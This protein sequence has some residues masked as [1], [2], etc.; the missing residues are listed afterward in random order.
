MKELD[1]EIVTGAGTGEVECEFLTGIAGSGKTF[2][3]RRRI[4]EDPDYGV[5]CA[6]TGIAAVNLGE[7]VTTLNSLLRYYNTDSLEMAH[8]T[9]RLARRL[10]DLAL[11]EGVRNI[12]I[13]E[14]SMMDA[15]Q[16]DLIYEG[17]EKFNYSDPANLLGWESPKLGLVLTG[18]FCQLPPVKGKFAFEAECWEKFEARTTVLTKCWRHAGDSR[19]LE[20]LNC[21]RAG[22]GRKG[23]GILADCGVG[24]HSSLDEDFE[25]STIIA[26]N[27][28]VDNYN[29]V[30]LAKLTTE[31]FTLRTI[32]WHSPDR[33]DVNNQW[34][35]IKIE[36]TYKPG[37]LVMLLDNDSDG[38]FV[39]GDLGRVV[40]FNR[41]DKVIIV[42]L[43]RTGEDVYVSPIWRRHL[44]RKVPPQFQ[45]VGSEDWPR[46]RQDSH[47]RSPEDLTYFDSKEKR[48][49]LGECLFYPLRLAWATTVH[50]SQGLTLD[51]VQIDLSHNFFGSP[52]MAYVALSRSRTPEGLRL[53]GTRDLLAS[54]ARLD[55]RCAPWVSSTSK[56]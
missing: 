35:S 49:V 17:I 50:K 21:F 53:V 20:G 13:D 6:T 22:L 34:K 8:Q 3:C 42:R 26:R 41:S 32:R 54:R 45:K 47:A 25:G 14:V 30:R 27:E 52:G 4:R 16:L 33:A 11:G 19:F 43:L 15:E 39:N 7:G 29:D 55:R 37:A 46:S 44:E 36:S 12:V 9:G 56:G 24:F 23:A 48:W 31:P 10:S 5:L 40:E 38:Q 18:D 2:E 1:Q 51:K 28:N